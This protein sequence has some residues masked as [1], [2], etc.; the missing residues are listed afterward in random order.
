VRR[1]KEKKKTAMAS[2]EN[3]APNINSIKPSTF[4]LNDSPVK[5]NTPTNSLNGTIRRVKE[6]SE[7]KK[8]FN[9]DAKK[10]QID[11]INKII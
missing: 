2:T 1:E 11:K 9:D 10:K 7:N 5:K 8:I 6:D 4:S 3:T